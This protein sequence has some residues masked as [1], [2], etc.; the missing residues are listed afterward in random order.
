[1]GDDHGEAPPILVFLVYGNFSI[2]NLSAAS[3]PLFT[4]GRPIMPGPTEHATGILKTPIFQQ[5]DPGPTASATASGGFGLAEGAGGT[6]LVPADPAMAVGSTYV[7]LA[8]NVGWRIYKKSDFQPVNPSIPYQ[9]LDDWFD[10]PSG[11]SANDPWLEYDRYNDRYLFV[12][13]A[14]N[15]LRD[16]GQI[17][18]AVSQTG[19]PRGNWCHYQWYWN[20]T[21]DHDYP[22]IGY[23]ALG[24][25]VTASLLNDGAF[26]FQAMY[27]M[28]KSVLY[29]SGCQMTRYPYGGSGPG[30]FVHSDGELVRGLWPATSQLTTTGEY[31]VATKRMTG[32]NSA[33]NLTVY[34]LNLALGAP[35]PMTSAY[36]TVDS[37]RGPDDASQPGTSTRIRTGFSQIYSVS[38]RGSSIWATQTVRGAGGGSQIRTYAISLPT[39]A[40]TTYFLIP[41]TGNFYYYP[42]QVFDT[43]GQA[44]MVFNW[45]G[46]GK[47]VSI[48]YAKFTGL[49]WGSPATIISGLG[50]ITYGSPARWGD[51]STAVVDDGAVW[52]YS[53]YA[54]ND[55]RWGTFFA[56]ITD[57]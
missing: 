27:A 7:A 1:M 36:V 15:Q 50:P 33:Q 54:R 43:L 48:Q 56:K 28:P 44:W 21:Y 17:E 32:T 38:V 9:S 42:A 57:P 51:Y 16:E 22:K 4:T 45:S 6:D 26:Q 24:V 14:F 34:N 29:G 55:N 52:M 18:F 31:F 19:D 2:A 37:Y 12:A 25:Y 41:P 11:Y 30:A 13:R 46:T 35:P 10:P 40:T 49:A 3:P 53:A 5:E 8:V 39:Y 23:D 47:Y 20:A